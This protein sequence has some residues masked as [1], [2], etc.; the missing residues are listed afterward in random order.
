MKNVK[1]LILRTAGTNCDKE[2]KHAFEL[3]GASAELM[4]VNALI[5]N[6]AS[7]KKYQI[8]AITRWFFIRR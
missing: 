6:K 2:T 7:I 3:S 8:L 5:K 1:V 4:H